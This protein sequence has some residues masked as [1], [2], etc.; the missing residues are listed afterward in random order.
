[1]SSADAVSPPELVHVTRDGVVESVHRGH[2]AVVAID[3]TVLA[4]LGNPGLPAYA[5]SALKPFQALATL[6]LLG[7][8]GRTLDTVGLAIACASH[9]GSDE[10]QVEAARLLADA[11]LDEEALLCPAALPDDVATLRRT[12]APTRLAHNCSGKHASFLAAQVAAGEDPAAYL[13]PN[14]RLQRRIAERLAEVSG[15]TPTG[16]GSD[17]CGAPAWILP[18]RALAAA[19]ARLAA[20]TGDLAPM[21]AALRARPD[22][23]GGT[24]AVDTALMLGDAR[25]VAKRGAEACF[26]AGALRPDGSPIGIAV[27]IAD[28]TGRATGP[29]VGAVLRGLGFHVDDA[30]VRPEVLGGGLPHGVIT[31]VPAVVEVAS[32]LGQPSG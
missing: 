29:V 3:G 16:P 17:G 32:R 25:I 4:A 20:G 28:G 13:D 21:A 23:V 22:L 19:F 30:L 24:S 5:R 15:A 27:K 2:V 11:G 9:E 7:E 6:E 31:A 26:G 8:A 14:G 1:M 18:L 10:H 12:P